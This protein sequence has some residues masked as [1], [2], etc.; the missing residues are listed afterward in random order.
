MGEQRL[1]GVILRAH[2]VRGEVIV[3]PRTDVP[4]RRFAVGR[5]LA[6]AVAGAASPAGPDLVVAAMRE[7]SGRLLVRFEGIDHRTGAEELRGVRLVIDAD[8]AGPPADAGEDADGLW[9]DSELIG[10]S[11]RLSDGSVVGVVTDVVHAAGNDLL[12]VRTQEGRSVL[13]P[14]VAALVPLVDGAA[15]RLVVDPPPGLLEL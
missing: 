10:L 12:V 14:F 1:V 9:W 2:G 11:A 15:G 7:H 6:R 3:A 13:I 5:V 4:R 8:D